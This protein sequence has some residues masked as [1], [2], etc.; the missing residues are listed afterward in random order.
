M[1]IGVVLVRS[2]LAVTILCPLAAATAAP[3]TSMASVGFATSGA[4]GT[5]KVT[6]ALG[7]RPGPTGLLCASP[8]IRRGAYDQRGVVRL[9][10]TGPA[11]V[12]P[13]GSDLLLGIDGSRDGTG[14]RPVLGTTHAWVRGGYRCA[15]SHGTVTCRRGAH[16]FVLSPSRLRVF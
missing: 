4:N 5:H 13:S 12:V 3:A 8:T 16:G 2:A 14:P 15:N 9:P 11:R 1:G 10:L 7:L 6:C